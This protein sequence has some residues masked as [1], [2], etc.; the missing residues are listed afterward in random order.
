MVLIS[1]GIINETHEPPTFLSVERPSY[2]KY[3]IPTTWF[4]NG[5]MAYGSFGDIH[6]KFV[7]HEDMD[8]AGMVTADADGLHSFSGLR[9]G[10]AKGYKSTAYHWTK[11]LAVHYTGME[12]VNVGGSFTFKIFAA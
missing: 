12:G 2:N 5:A 10:R 8:G 9:G 1:A 11:N 3:I 7:L 4:G 6:A